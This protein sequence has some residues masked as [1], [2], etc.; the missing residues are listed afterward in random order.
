MSACDT[1]AL[2]RARTFLCS[3]SAPGDTSAS[4]KEFP[5]NMAGNC[6]AHG[7]GFCGQR[8]VP[9]C[10]CW[11]VTSEDIYFS[12][13][14]SG[15]RRLCTRLMLVPRARFVFLHVCL[16]YANGTKKEK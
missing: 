4:A 2:N 13:V 12:K 15:K 16:V 9:L 11:R 1:D 7:P 3:F 14:E 10:L 6:T 5:S 8:H